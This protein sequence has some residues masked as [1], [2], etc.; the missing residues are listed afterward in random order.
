[1]VN[2]EL[3][4]MHACEHAGGS[5]TVDHEGIGKLMVAYSFA[6]DDPK[7]KLKNVP[8]GLVTVPVMMETPEKLHTGEIS[9]TKAMADRKYFFH[10]ERSSSIGD[11]RG[12]E[13]PVL[14]MRYGGKE[15][16]YAPV[17]TVRNV[18][19]FGDS[20]E[21]SY[22]DHD[23]AIFFHKDMK[24]FTKFVGSLSLALKDPEIRG[25]MS[26]AEVTNLATQFYTASRY[27]RENDAP[28]RA[29]LSENF[30]N[31]LLGRENQHLSLDQWEELI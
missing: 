27:F 21:P 25:R 15:P 6:R 5:E 23:N 13:W 30:A 20:M 16:F 18:A 11:G 22:S 7:L 12:R 9:V 31:S 3:M 26:D 14:M 10:P 19:L 8:F 2:Y 28:V 4:K 24:G 29:R 17:E 1:M